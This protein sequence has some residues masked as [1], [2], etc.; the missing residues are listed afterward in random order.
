MNFARLPPLRAGA[1]VAAGLVGW[2]ALGAATASAQPA[3]SGPPAGAGPAS[4]RVG[5]Y[6][7]DITEIDEERETCTF[8]GTLTFA[9]EDPRQ[10]FDPAAVGSSERVYQGSYEV[11]ELYEGWWPQLVQDNES[12]ALERQGSLLRIDPAGRLTYVEEIDTVAKSPMALRRFPFDRQ[13]CVGVFQI[14]GFGR[15]TV[16]L[17]ADA[18]TTGSKRGHVSV[19]EWR[20]EAIHSDD[21]VEERVYA[22]R[23]PEDVSIF[24]VTIQLRRES[25][26]MLRLVIA[27]LVLL[28]MLSWSV[29]WMDQASLGDRMDISFI[30]ILT[31]VAFQIVISEHLPRIPYFT[32]MDT[33]LY[34]N[35]GV[36]FAS[37]MVNLR[38]GW[39]DQHGRREVGDRLDRR[40]RWL[41]PLGY[42][43]LLTLTCLYYLGLAP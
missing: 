26:F 10:A 6:L 31:V 30:G 1:V 42:A 34:I 40:C 14:L 2:V 25:A 11:A 18:A 19:S 43:S 8:E 38:V 35:Y 21:R 29:F 4:V 20:F 5:F 37:V 17:V 36:L 33:F 3:L 16:E 22:D 27:P 32:L 41:F 28:V 39:L 24:V 7:T 9:W 15:D 13:T 23:H 12:G